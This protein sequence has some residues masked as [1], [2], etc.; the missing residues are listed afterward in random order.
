MNL[1]FPFH[2]DG[3][4]RT[5]ETDTDEH[6]R[7]LIEQVLF[8]VARRAGQPSDLWQR[9]DATWSLLRTATSSPPPPNFWCRA[10]CSN[11]LAI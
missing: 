2:F 1:D 4:G 11:G 10:R 7:D 3:R 6:I 9:A 5:A 8:T